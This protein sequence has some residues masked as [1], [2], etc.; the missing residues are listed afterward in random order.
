MQHRETER[1]FVVAGHFCVCVPTERGAVRVSAVLKEELTHQHACF[2]IFSSC[3]ILVN[4][5][6]CR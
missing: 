3:V 6:D 2:F 5:Y 4:A 1:V